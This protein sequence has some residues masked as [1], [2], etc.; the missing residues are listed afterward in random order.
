VKS[1]IQKLLKRLGIYHR[2]KA[3]FLYRLY[4]SFADRSVINETSQELSFY[5]NLLSGFN[6]GD[7]IFDIGANQ[8]T[9]TETFL[10]LGAKVVAVDPDETNKEIL[11]SK[12]LKYRLVP[13]PV[14]VVNRAVSDKSETA[15]MFVDAP[16]S[17]K[18]TFSRKW[19]DTLR[20]DDSR[21]GHSLD[22]RQSKEVATTTLENLFADH[23]VPFFVKIDVEGFELSVLQGMQRPVPYLS[24]EVNLPE[25]RPEGLQ[26]IEV[27]AGVSTEGKF[28]YASDCTSEL[29]LKEWVSAAQITQ[30]LNTCSEPS[31]EVFWKT[32]LPAARRS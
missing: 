6:P 32:P 8:G 24:F 14:V 20:T 22:F 18:N 27:L 1:Q 21:F 23:G 26:C 17:A 3:S 19:V 5:R 2:L 12:F 10:R 15:T 7:V 4:W 29:A 25:F 9:K 16:G 13:K 30:V 28:N 31:I 11:E